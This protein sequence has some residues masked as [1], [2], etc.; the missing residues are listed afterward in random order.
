MPLQEVDF[1]HNLAE[2]I[3][4]MRRQGLLLTSVD[5]EGKPNV[6]TIGWGN[7]G[8][9]WGK[10]IFVVLVRPSR[11]TFRNVEETM[12]FVID[13]PTDEMHEACLHC[14]TVSGRDHDKFADCGFTTVQAETVDAPLIEQCLMHYECRVVHKND[15]M[16]SQL[17]PTVR[18]EC[19]AS[20]DFHRI[21]YGQILRVSAKA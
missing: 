9:I 20:G 17:D 21:Y 7:P 1:T 5:A 11:F 16:D 6:M 10:P 3:A 13:V 14:G 12:Q 8:I 4:L 2:N 19:Y 18:S 15:V